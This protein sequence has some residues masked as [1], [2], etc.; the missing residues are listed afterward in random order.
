VLGIL[1]YSQWVHCIADNKPSV[2]TG[3]AIWK[4]RRSGIIETRHTLDSY[5]RRV[6]PPTPESL[7]A[8]ALCRESLGTE[9]LQVGR[10]RSLR[11][12]AVVRTRP[13]L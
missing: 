4:N 2:K 1:P 10:S 3:E 11:I 13:P 5:K 12:F 8:A 7:R 6:A 9:R